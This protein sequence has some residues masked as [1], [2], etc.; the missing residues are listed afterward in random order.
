MQIGECGM[1][2]KEVFGND[3]RIRESEFK[4]KK[5]LSYARTVK[6]TDKIRGS[7]FFRQDEINLDRI[8]G[9]VVTATSKS[10]RALGGAVWDRFAGRRSKRGKGGV[11]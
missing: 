3:P 2:G 1:K 8:W 10:R 5:S 4:N 11:E 6:G 9:S 7:L